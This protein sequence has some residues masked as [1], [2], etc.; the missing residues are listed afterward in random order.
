MGRHGTDRKVVPYGITA[1]TDAPNPDSGE[2]CYHTNTQLFATIDDHN[3]GKIGEAVTEPWNAPPPG[4]RPSGTPSNSQVY[5]GTPSSVSRRT[6][7]VSTKA[8]PR[9]RL[10]SLTRESGLPCHSLN[11]RR[12]V[13]G[14]GPVP[15]CRTGG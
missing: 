7:P 14:A 1:G 2:E 8:L 5:R 13:L 4:A 15:G 9:R 10:P 12:Q 3:R 6:R 11:R